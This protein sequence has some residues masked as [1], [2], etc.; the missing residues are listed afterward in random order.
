MKIVVTG[1]AGYLGS[2]LVDYL[3]GQG[4]YVT[5]VDNFM[6]RQAPFGHLCYAPQFEIVRG[7][8]RDMRIMKDVLKTAD[9]LIPL[10]AL[11]GAPLCDAN[12]TE[13]RAINVDAIVSATY[14]MSPAQAIVIPISNS[15]YGVGEQNAYCTEDTPMRPVS[16]YGATK[17]EVEGLILDRGNAIALRLATVFGMSPRMRLDLLVNDFVWRACRDRAL[18]L[19]EGSFRR[20]FIHVRDV[21]DAFLHVLDNWGSMVKTP[22]YNVGNTDL[23]MTKKDLCRTIQS[24]IPAFM[25]HEAPSGFDPDKRDY[26]VSNARIENTGW[27]AQYGLDHGIPELIKGFQMYRAYEHGNV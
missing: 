8:A 21:A 10:A 12:P 14:L 16:I 22:I 13:A 1:G 2:T 7:D 23:N 6:W 20:N 3:I 11:V 15:G 17:V 4:H 18:V 5:V 26:V 19:F 27:F 24:H 25:W 9:I